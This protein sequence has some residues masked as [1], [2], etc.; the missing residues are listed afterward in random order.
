MS[1]SYYCCGYGGWNGS[2]VMVGVVAVV[3]ERRHHHLELT[4]RQF[5]RVEHQFDYYRDKDCCYCCWCWQR[6]TRGCGYGY[7]CSFEQRSFLEKRM[8]LKLTLVLMMDT[9]HKHLNPIVVS[10]VY[11]TMLYDQ[12]SHDLDDGLVKRHSL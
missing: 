2:I 4:Y 8:M 10:E 3:A 1:S 6:S 11:W 12:H 5:E 9:L 7:G